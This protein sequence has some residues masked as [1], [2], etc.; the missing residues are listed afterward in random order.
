MFILYN[1]TFINN[2]RICECYVV[3][4]L[5]HNFYFTTCSVCVGRNTTYVRSS[6]P[7]YILFNIF[8]TLSPSTTVFPLMFF[9]LIGSNHFSLRRNSGFTFFSHSLRRIAPKGRWDDRDRTQLW[10]LV[11]TRLKRLRI[12]S[13]LRLF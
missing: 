1:K 6:T 3:Y 11:P 8:T 5:N 9:P 2:S 13:I 7:Q 4:N 10:T 12:A